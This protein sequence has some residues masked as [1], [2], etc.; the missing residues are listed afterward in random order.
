MAQIPLQ[1]PS[2]PAGSGA[3]SDP[4][5]GFF[6]RGDRLSIFEQGHDLV[7]R[8]LAA[9]D[10]DLCVVGH[11]IGVRRYRRCRRQPD[12][13]GDDKGKEWEGISAGGK[14][15]FFSGGTHLSAVSFA[16]RP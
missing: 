2:F 16:A 7:F 9:S 12:Q 3:D 13:Q 11:Y 6:Q 10:R 15:T 14:R 1:H 8:S 5:F 4:V